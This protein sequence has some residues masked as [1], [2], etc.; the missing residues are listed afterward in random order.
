MGTTW[1]YRILFP[2]SREQTV[3]PVLC[4]LRVASMCGYQ[5][6]KRPDGSLAVYGETLPEEIWTASGC[7]EQLLKRNIALD[8]VGQD[9]MSYLL[10]AIAPGF[11][12]EKLFRDYYPQDELLFCQLDLSIDNAY[13]EA[14]DHREHLSQFQE[15]FL[16][17]FEAVGAIFGYSIHEWTEEEMLSTLR[18]HR[19]IRDCQLPKEVF[20]LTIA[21]DNSGLDLTRLGDY[22][23][24]IARRESGVLVA[25]FCDGPWNV[26]LERLQS[27]NRSSGLG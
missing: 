15:M 26:D 3:E 18:V 23:A 17:M 9:G 10:S 5:S 20:W 11:G 19:D 25:S 22:G 16:R 24:R 7:A 6:A 12:R 2:T 1:H 4:V 27:L 21:G 14:S 13:V 8:C